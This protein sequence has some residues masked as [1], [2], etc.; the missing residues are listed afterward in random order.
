MILDVLNFGEYSFFVWAAFIFTFASC[1]FLYIKTRSDLL[2]LEKI[3]FVR[4]EKLAI[5]TKPEKRKRKEI[6]STNPSY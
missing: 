6:F 4:R 3:F 5:N 1:F 2:K